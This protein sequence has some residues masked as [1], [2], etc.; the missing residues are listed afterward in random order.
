MIER[1]SHSADETMRIAA[2]LA[3]RLRGGAFLALHGD[4]G[5]GKTCFVRGLARG[6]GIDPRAVSSPTFVIMHEY[7]SAAA[8]EP[9]VLIHVDA[10]RLKGAAELEGI[11]WEEL[12]DRRDAVIAL[13]WPERIGDALPP[14]RIDVAIEHR[15]GDKRFIRIEAVGAAAAHESPPVRAAARRPCPVC[16]MQVNADSEAF[17]FC[18][19]RCRLADLHR[20]MGGA[21]RVSR[22][23]DDPRDWEEAA[24]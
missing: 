13:E 22:P 14:D 16:R 21:Y 5:A 3:Q 23:A 18:S 24:E 10:Y 8:H 4:L 17:P 15:G 2:D 6:L 9:R 7:E 12:L 1:L 20:W 11:G 19:Q